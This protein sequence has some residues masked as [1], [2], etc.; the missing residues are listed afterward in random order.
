MVNDKNMQMIAN[1]IISKVSS[2]DIRSYLAQCNNEKQQIHVIE[3]IFNK[4]ILIKFASEYQ[5][6][7]TY[8]G[9]NEQQKQYYQNKL[10]NTHDLMCLVFS[11]LT[12]T[13][14]GYYKWPNNGFVGD[15]IIAV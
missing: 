3:M 9:N 5:E 11:Y 8:N 2:C 13:S 15:L 12:F 6:L 4:V 10:F 7:I 14:E 1:N